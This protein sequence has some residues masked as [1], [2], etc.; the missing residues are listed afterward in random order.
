MHW[1]DG[2]E[3]SLENTMLLCT[4]HHRLLHEGGYTIEKDH[5]GRFYFR[6]SQGKVMPD[7]HWTYASRDGFEGH[8]V[9]HKA[10]GQSGAATR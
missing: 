2:G 7:V 3:T 10:G 6:R 4:K 9:Q 5:K 8:V 1:S